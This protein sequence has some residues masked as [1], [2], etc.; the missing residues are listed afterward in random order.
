MHTSMIGSSV[1]LSAMYSKVSSRTGWAHCRSSISTTS[2]WRRARLSSSRRSAHEVSPGS[3]LAAS[4]MPSS[5][6]ICDSAC[7]SRSSEP[8]SDVSR[9]CATV[10]SSVG[11]IPA[12]R[13]AICTTGQ[14]VTASPYSRQCPRSTSARSSRPRRNSSASRVLPTPARPRT[15]TRWQLRSATTRAN[16]A[17]SSSCSRSRPSMGARRR[18]IRPGLPGSTSSSRNADTGSATPCN[19]SSLTSSV[20]TA[21]RTSWWVSSPISTPP[22]SPISSRRL[23]TLAAGPVIRSSSESASCTS[24]LP[25]LIPTR[26]CNG[27]PCSRSRSSPSGPSACCSSSPARTA[28]RASSS[29]ATGMPN[30][31]MTLSPCRLPGS[32]PWLP[33]TRLA[34]SAKRSM[35]RC[36]VS[37]P[38]CSLSS[39]ERTTSQNTTVTTLSSPSSAEEADLSRVPQVRQKFACSGTSVPQLGQVAIVVISAVC[40]ILTRIEQGACAPAQEICSPS[41]WAS[42]AST[43]SERVNSS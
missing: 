12:A 10:G 17:S 41:R 5:C 42:S 43:T 31:A 13:R 28:R 8:N 18:G 25:V 38:S 11:A 19:A 27:T 40:R 37:S 26:T 35:V 23:A 1:A 16:R 29:C 7:R 39:V 21:S 14:N 34:V 24:T 36:S 2:G 32:P 15:V 6:S 9:S 20:R 30:T 22:G 33:S 3:S 4:V